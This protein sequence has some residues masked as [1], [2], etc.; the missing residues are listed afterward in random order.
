MFSGLTRPTQVCHGTRSA[1]GLDFADAMEPRNLELYASRLGCK[2]VFL[3]ALAALQRDARLWRISSVERGLCRLLGFGDDGVLIERRARFGAQPIAVGDWVVLEDER[4]DPAHVAH[5]L[6]R[7][8]WL[9]RG[10][11]HRE[12]EAQL[13]AANLDT[14]FIVAAF[15]ETPK[16]VARSLRAGRLDRFIS[17]VRQG[18]ATPVVVLNKLDLSGRN[19]GELEALRNALAARLGGVDVVCASALDQRGL[20]A[21]SERIP[22]GD[23]V[24]FIGPSGV[25][26]SSL[27]N[28][29]LG[30]ERQLL[31]AVRARDRKGRHTRTPRTLLRLPWASRSSLNTHSTSSDRVNDRPGAFINLTRS[32]N[33][34]AVKGTSRSPRK[35]R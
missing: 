18:G 34:V 26:K 25:G 14:V 30:E 2:P 5:V 33:S 20:E 6:E 15:A 11:A 4:Q 23:T 27:I 22:P 1:L 32:R 24:A 28:A 21:L 29:V 19:E 31:S 3:H 35:T 16:L 7:M 17:A 10:S 12:G 9:Q 13:I 8:T